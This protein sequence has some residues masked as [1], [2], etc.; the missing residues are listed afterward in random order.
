MEFLF[1]LS[2]GLIMFAYFGYPAVLWVMSRF[3]HKRRMVSDIVN[4]SVSIIISVATE[5]TDRILAKLVNTWELIYPGHKEVIVA[6]DGPTKEL[7]EWFNQRRTVH[8]SAFNIKV[9]ILEQ[10]GGKE[11]A[12]KRAIMASTGDILIFTD[13]S[14]S[15][16]KNTIIQ[17]V[18]NFTRD[19][20][21]GAVDGMSET[22][23]EEGIYLKY[24]NKIRELES[25]VHSL[26]TLGGC[27]F[28]VRRSMV[29]SDFDTKMQSDFR[30][31]LMTRHY[32][33]RS[34]LDKE[35]VA[36]F[37]YLQDPTKEKDRKHRTVVRGLNTFFNH[38]FLLNPFEYGFFSFQLVCHKLLKWLVP[39]FMII[40]FV[41]SHY[42]W[43][44]TTSWLYC[45]ISLG[46]A[47][48]Y[49]NA[50]LGMTHQRL[51]QVYYRIPGFF[52]MANLAILKAWYSYAR[53]ER[54]VMWDASVR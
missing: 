24:E 36:R 27:L 34:V 26:V 54:F 42:I 13:V 22:G 8:N 39:F 18:S 31:A 49:V 29:T 53:G 37:P 12:Q 47:I 14:T 7:V 25:K 2:A 5:S 19:G 20:S 4:P 51:H 44:T 48:F 41:T 28:A 11:A 30:T 9:C 16:W 45:F 52:L 46:Q 33:F 10:K 23:G 38:L 3:V 15:L 40:A 21:I 43:L 6:L 17:L 50:Y 1:W 35:A 32:G